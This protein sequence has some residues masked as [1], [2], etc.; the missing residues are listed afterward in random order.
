MTAA[1]ER[2]Q[3]LANAHYRI[4]LS[5]VRA[6]EVAAELDRLESATRD[7]LGP[8]NFD[9]EPGA[10]FRRILRGLAAPDIAAERRTR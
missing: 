1:A 8:S 9:S 4:E 3:Q 10:S 6:A 5:P 7:A 2:V